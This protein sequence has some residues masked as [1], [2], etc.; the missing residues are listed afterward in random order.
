LDQLRQRGL[1]ETNGNKTEKTR[2]AVT[3]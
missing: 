3:D 1:D 2:R